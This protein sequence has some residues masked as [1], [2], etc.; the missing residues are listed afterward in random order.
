[1]VRVAFGAR[2]RSDRE[3]WIRITRRPAL[4]KKSFLWK[5]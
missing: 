4:N 1:M 3:R 2:L 5:I